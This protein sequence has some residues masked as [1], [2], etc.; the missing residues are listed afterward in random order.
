M[1]FTAEQQAYI[2]N[3][4]K[5]E[6]EKME[7][8]VNELQIQLKELEQYKPKQK[9]EKEIEFEKKEAELWNKEKALILKESGLDKFA[10]FING[11]NAENLHKNIDSF[12]NVL[13][14][15]K[16]DNSF[17]PQEHR[18]SSKTEYEK[19]AKEGNTLG[20]IQHKLSKLFQN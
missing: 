2:D 7:K 20:M 11:D 18:K 10:N 4:L 8:Q 15:L 19:H 17:I 3:L 16:I 9:T 6:K 14:E 12:K 13:K 1:E 5:Q